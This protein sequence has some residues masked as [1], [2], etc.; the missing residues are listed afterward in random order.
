MPMALDSGVQQAKHTSE[1]LLEVSL[2]T[3]A[4]RSIRSV[5]VPGLEASSRATANPTAPAPMTYSVIFD[6]LR[7]PSSAWA[8][9]TNAQHE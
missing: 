8:D 3:E 7:V 6:Q 5:D 9:H 4:C 1:F 2:P